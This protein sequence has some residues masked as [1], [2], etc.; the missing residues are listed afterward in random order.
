MSS[1]SFCFIFLT[2]GFNQPDVNRI[3]YQ[4]YIY[5]FNFAQ[6]NKLFLNFTSFIIC[7]VIKSMFLVKIN[8]KL[9]KNI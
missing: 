2:A 6:K 3:F 7:T 8:K 4:L 1:A 9:K 5:I